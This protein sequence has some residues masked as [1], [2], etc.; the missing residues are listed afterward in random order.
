MDKNKTLGCIFGG[1]IGDALGYP[2]E[3]RK[4]IKD[5]EITKYKD[6]IGI[7]SDDTQMTLFTV[8]GILWRETRLSAKGIAPDIADAVYYAYLDWLE[9]QDRYKVNLN[10]VTWLKYQPELKVKRDP[11]MTCLSA[12]TSGKRGTLKEPIN[13]SKGC[14][15][16]MRVAPI[17][18]CARSPE[19][20]GEYG[21]K[22]SA[23]THG[24][25]YSV[26]ASFVFAATINILANTE[27]SILAAI[28]TA[29]SLLPDFCEGNKLCSSN[30]IEDFASIINNAIALAEQ[31]GADIDNIKKLGEGWVAE[32]ALAIAIYSCVKYSD[33]FEN[34]IICAVNHDGDSDSTGSIAGNIIGA[35]LGYESLPQ[36]YVDNLELKDI[37][38]EIATDFTFEPTRTTRQGTNWDNKYIYCK[39]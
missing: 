39:R 23:I 35:S 26:L 9:T 32:E 13:D 24:H 15:G 4:G 38:L 34:A 33:S 18:L 2:I 22:C 28:T 31:E 6:D 7:I 30:V 25:I 14:G 20:A 37:I 1:A 11:G 36:Y 12:L 16:V 5:K 3:F 21:A 29:M 8:N 19:L 17:G 10:R 27:E